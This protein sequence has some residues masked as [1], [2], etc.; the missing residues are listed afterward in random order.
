MI[1]R[2]DPG[3][4]K[5]ALLD[6]V[7]ATA[8]VRTL[9]ATGF[10]SEADLP[11][12]ALGDLLRPI[13]SSL[14]DVPPLQADA[15]RGALGLGSTTAVDP[16]SVEVATASL[17]RAAAAVEPLLLV[18]DDM[19][20]LD[21]GSLNA[22][23]YVARRAAQLPVAVVGAARLEEMPPAVASLP[24]LSLCPLAAGHAEEL[25]RSRASTDV[26]PAVVR[27]LVEAA[28]G[29]PLALHEQS[30]GLSPEELLVTCRSPTR[31]PYR[32][33]QV[34]LPPPHRFTTR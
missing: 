17:L 20:W 12:A 16:V 9:R 15:L 30:C 14:D 31:S 6:E 8:A 4:G 5:T 11:F 1:V 33:K 22:V 25:L 3:I 21:T 27:S 23:V 2:G 18:V 26:V 28:G 34:G 13:L 19:Q 7:V 29:N 24:S 10:E 32:P